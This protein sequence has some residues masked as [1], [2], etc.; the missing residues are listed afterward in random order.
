[1]VSYSVL[2][3]DPQATGEGVHLASGSCKLLPPCGT[4]PLT[5][6]FWLRVTS[7][8]IQATSYTTDQTLLW[9]SCGTYAHVCA[10]ADTR[11][12]AHPFAKCLLLC[13]GLALSEV[14]HYSFSSVN[15]E[16]KHE[17]DVE[18]STVGLGIPTI[19]LDV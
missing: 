2:Q 13:Q 7:S 19:T 6:I 4:S 17:Q 16:A 10:C 11:T 3:N 8:W 12:H 15:M 5:V 14:I 9:K 1:M 18:H